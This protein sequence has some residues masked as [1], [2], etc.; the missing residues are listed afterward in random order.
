MTGVFASHRNAAA[1][2]DV[3]SRVM[4]NEFI[5]SLAMQSM[6]GLAVARSPHN[7]Q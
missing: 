3:E 1:Y 2:A 7:T 4:N 5:T 6:A